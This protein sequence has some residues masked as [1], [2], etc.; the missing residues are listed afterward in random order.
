MSRIG[1]KPVLVPGNVKVAVDAGSNTVKVE[2]PKGKL[3]F[4]HHAD[5]S[6]NYAEADNRVLPFPKI[7]EIRV[8]KV[9]WGTTR[10]RIA[11]MVQGVVDGY[12]KKLQVIGVG[13]NAQAQGKTLR[14][15]VGYCHPV[16]LQAP[17]GVEFKAGGEFVSITGPDKEQVGQ[18]AA[19]VRSK[20]P[21][22]PYG[23]RY[24][25]RRRV[26]HPQGWQ[27][28]GLSPRKLFMDR[29]KS[30]AQSRPSPSRSSASHPRRCRSAS[31]RGVPQQQTHLRPGVDDLTAHHCRRL[32]G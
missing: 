16:D 5:V 3:E 12:E 4:V 32:Y 7:V 18:F 2:G 20:R 27:V 23:Q 9:S 8:D 11:C 29:I 25:L 19:V 1:T 31:P 26:C 28:N 6:V 17:E 30:G 24:P 15:N 21:P 22:E 14:L 10:A 13:W